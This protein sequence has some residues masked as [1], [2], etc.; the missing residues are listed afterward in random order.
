MY[1]ALKI[2]IS[3]IKKYV[4]FVLLSASTMFGRPQTFSLPNNAI[5]KM[6]LR[7]DAKFG[8]FIHLTK[9]QEVV[10]VYKILNRLLLKTSGC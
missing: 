8:I 4:G 6:A 2:Q 3:S 7:K 1:A 9:Q 5:S 10:V